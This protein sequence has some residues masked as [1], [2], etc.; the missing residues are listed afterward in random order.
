MAGGSYWG[1]DDRLFQANVLLGQQGLA[2][3]RQS[4]KLFTACAWW[5]I[6]WLSLLTLACLFPFLSLSN[7][8]CSS[9]LP[10]TQRD[11]RPHPP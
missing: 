11:Q 8:T 2:A 7:R 4:D 9:A 10:Y 6:G 5:N 3:T 1:R